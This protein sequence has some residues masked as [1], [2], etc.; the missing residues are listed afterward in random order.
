MKSAELVESTP[1]QHRA[2]P[3]LRVIGKWAR[4]AGPLIALI[5]LVIL[6]LLLN[7]SFLS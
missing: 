2:E 5:L 4:E 1:Q 7:P 6:G 3:Q